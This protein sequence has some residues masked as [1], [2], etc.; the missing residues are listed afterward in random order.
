MLCRWRSFFGAARGS[1]SR[2]ELRVQG[3]VPGFLGAFSDHLRSVPRLFGLSQGRAYRPFESALHLYCKRYGH[4]SR[5]HLTCFIMLHILEVSTF[6]WPGR[7]SS[8]PCH[9]STT[10][11]AWPCSHVA[12]PNSPRGMEVIKL[13]GYVYEEKLAIANQY[14]IPQTIASQI[15]LQDSTSF[16]VKRS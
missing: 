7:S 16:H 13:A 11:S 15:Q 8:R 12:G 2:A 14:L 1:R 9:A 5:P 6:S 3:L 10:A 4:D